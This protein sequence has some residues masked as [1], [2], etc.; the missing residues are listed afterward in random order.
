VFRAKP[1]DKIAAGQ[2]IAAIHAR[3]EKGLEIA[4]AALDSAIT[5]ASGR[6]KPPLPLVS[7]RITR[8]GVQVLE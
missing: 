2:S 4:R 5:M 6:A 3:D 1:G 8:E 7:H